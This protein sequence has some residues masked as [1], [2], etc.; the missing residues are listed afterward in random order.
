MSIGMMFYINSIMAL[1]A[2]I[3]IPASLLISRGIVKIS[4]KYFQGMQNS[5][6]DLNGYVQENMTGFSV[7]KV[8]GRE[9]Q[10]L[11]GF[12]KVNHTLKHYGFRAAFIS[13]LMMPLVQLTAYA[14][15]IAMAILGSYYVIGGVIVV[16]QLQAFIQ[17]IWQVS[18]PMGNITQLS[19]ILQSAS[20]SAK[21]VFE[22]LDEP[23]EPMNEVDQILP[24]EI[25][26]EVVFDHVG[27]SYDPRKPLI[28]DLNFTVKA[29]QTVAIVIQPVLG[30][31]H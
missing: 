10:T 24:A 7:L 22:I 19:S 2:I 9:E 30:K 31:P 28:K 16:G 23:E 17:Y 5:L 25:Q 14:T 13:G 6:G 1:I 26:G 11:T 20:A 21:R 12:K 15:Y 3:M 4:Q 27:F 29:G 18:Q 8:Y